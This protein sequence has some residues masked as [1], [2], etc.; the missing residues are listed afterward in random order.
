METLETKM[1]TQKTPKN[2]DT[3]KIQQKKRQITINSQP[4]KRKN[5][6]QIT[7]KLQSTDNQKNADTIN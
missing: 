4:K 6:C 7:A 5:D 2:A 3:T 1:E